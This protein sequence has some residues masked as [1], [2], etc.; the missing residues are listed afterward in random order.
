MYVVSKQF[1]FYAAHRNTDLPGKCE[2]IHG[3][4]YRLTVS[5]G[6]EINGSVSIPFASVEDAALPLIDQMDHSLLLWSGDPARE[7]LLASGAC[8]KVYEVPFQT[9]CEL[10]AS[11]IMDELV[12][13]GLN[14][15]SIHLQETETSAVTV[16]RCPR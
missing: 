10:M 4:C 13:A 8:C 7:M 15:T 14:V 9:S 1:R 11:H 2:S 16:S 3:H 6:S 5:V 12:A